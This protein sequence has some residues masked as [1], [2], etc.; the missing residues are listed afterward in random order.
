MLYGG[1]PGSVV[2]NHRTQIGINDIL[3]IGV[4]D[5][6]TRQVFSDE[7]NPAIRRGWFDMELHFLPRM[8]S[9][10]GTTYFVS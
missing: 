1:N 4:N 10:S 8:K 5:R 2:S 9:D 3:G 7:T 6:L